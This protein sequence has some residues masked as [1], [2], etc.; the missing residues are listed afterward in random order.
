MP[1]AFLDTSILVYA[2]DARD[3]IRQQRAIEV[4]TGHLRGKTGVVST[5]VLQEYAVAAEGKLG[6][7]PDTVLRQLAL[8][9]SLEVVLVSPP[10]IRRAL[11]LHHRYRIAY[12]DA[13]IL[14]AAEHA[15]CDVVLSEDL[16]AGQL[17]AAVTVRNPFA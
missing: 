12:W 8:L 10:L 14:A 17:Y 16:N 13:G 11:E 3:P 5:Q 4:V 7:D 9:E 15:R 6:Q 2:N 1:K